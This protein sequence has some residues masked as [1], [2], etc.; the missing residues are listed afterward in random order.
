MS[1]NLPNVQYLAFISLQ[2]H[3]RSTN[4]YIMWCRR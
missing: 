4:A 1:R 3:I 2:S